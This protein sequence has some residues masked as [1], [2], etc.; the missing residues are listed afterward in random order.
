MK[1]YLP[2][3]EGHV[4]PAMVR[5][6]RAFLD[7]CYYP[8][9]NSLNEC[10]LAN[11][12]DALDRFHHERCIFQETGVRDRGPK[13][14]SLP[15]QHAMKH[16]RHLIQEFGAPNGICSSITE[17]K[18]IKAVKEPWRRSN[19]FNALGQML[20][21]NQRLDKLAA[22]RV[23]FK[24][25]GM[26]EGSVLSTSCTDHLSG[27][28]HDHSQDHIGSTAGNANHDNDDNGNDTDGGDEIQMH[29]DGP[30][31]LNYVRLAKTQGTATFLFVFC[32]CN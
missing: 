11:L 9:R 26:L 17:S 21:T 16:Y 2:A 5:T 32:L 4:P 27:D 14:F 10:A 24:T 15:R 23:D 29:C 3:I 7:F 25:C 13:G 30:H 18:H 28:H 19:H 20:V 1:V 12:Q 6:V 22:A 8:R 31:V